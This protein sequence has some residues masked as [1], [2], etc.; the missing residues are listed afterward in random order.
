MGKEE[1][2]TIEELIARYELEPELCDIYVEG[3]LD[4]SVID[5]YLHRH[6]RSRYAIYEISSVHIDAGSVEAC[7]L[8]VNNKGRVVYLAIRFEQALDIAMVLC[9]VD[10]DCDKLL[11]R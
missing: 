8:S 2:R 7:K 9:I 1:R 3:A 4:A 10:S 6:S 5:S 11:N